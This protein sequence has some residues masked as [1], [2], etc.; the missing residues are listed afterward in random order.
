M[1]FQA[2]EEL[3][4]ETT[5]FYLFVQLYLSINMQINGYFVNLTKHGIPASIVYLRLKSEGTSILDCSSKPH[6][7]VLSLEIVDVPNIACKV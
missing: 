3:V 4:D 5:A 6:L 1:G 2:L 7:F